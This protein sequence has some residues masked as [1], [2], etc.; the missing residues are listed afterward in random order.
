[1]S[2]DEANDVAE[3]VEWQTDVLGCF[4][5]TSE[6]DRGQMYATNMRVNEQR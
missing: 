2:L 3:R 6:R 4:E 1:M 5:E